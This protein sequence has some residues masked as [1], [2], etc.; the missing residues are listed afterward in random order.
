M[1][2][3]NCGHTVLGSLAIGKHV[4]C[5]TSILAPALREPSLRNSLKHPHSPNPWGP[6]ADP[7]GPRLWA[8]TGCFVWSANRFQLPTAPL[9]PG[10]FLRSTFPWRLHI[11]T[12]TPRESDGRGGGTIRQMEASNSHA[13]E[14]ELGLH[15][16][17]V[18]IRPRWRPR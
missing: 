15:T 11:L 1:L 3:L 6:R 4:F 12:P 7:Q 17:S 5:S 13:C 18:Q 9:W 10:P 8:S 2:S 14:R 16:S